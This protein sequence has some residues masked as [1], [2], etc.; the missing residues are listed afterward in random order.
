MMRVLGFVPCS[1]PAA[2][3]S[4]PRLTVEYM[5]LIMLK[6]KSAEAPAAVQGSCQHGIAQKHAID[7][8]LQE[9]HFSLIP[10]EF[11]PSHTHLN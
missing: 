1:L 8:S 11:I 6:D 9:T 2:Q 4:E 10:S 3:G 5:G 7:P